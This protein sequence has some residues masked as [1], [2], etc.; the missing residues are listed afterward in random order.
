MP[1][2]AQ[3]G[4]CRHRLKSPFNLMKPTGWLS[5]ARAVYPPRCSS[6]LPS[7]EPLAER[8]FKLGLR[9][10][11]N[12]HSRRAFGL[13]SPRRPEFLHG[14]VVSYQHEREIGAVDSGEAFPHLLG[15]R[16]AQGAC[17]LDTS[18]G[19]LRYVTPDA[20]SSSPFRLIRVMPLVGSAR[21]EHWL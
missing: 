6:M 4:V 5:P 9:D 19:C 21:Y 10:F 15:H 20:L 12:R 1:P 8:V 14:S 3:P 18:R 2:G 7:P 11:D 16:S 17:L 13:G